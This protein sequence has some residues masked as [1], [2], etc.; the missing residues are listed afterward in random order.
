MFF[1]AKEV[2]R[3]IPI[4]PN[5]ASSIS[6]PP[7][8]WK[9]SKQILCYTRLLF[10]F[11][12]SLSSRLRKKSLISSMLSQPFP[13]AAILCRLFFSFLYAPFFSWCILAIF[14]WF[15]DSTFCL[16]CHVAAVGI[17][18]IIRRKRIQKQ[19]LL[20]SNISLCGWS[21]KLT[22]IDNTQRILE[23]FVIVSGAFL[24]PRSYDHHLSFR[25]TL[26]QLSR[27][28]SI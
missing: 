24:G 16:S 22:D 9:V 1:S 25:P 5:T 28:Y 7:S 17:C 12:Y 26:P 19:I 27:I 11:P 10:P 6:T 18:E 2:D 3:W 8:I 13:S 4:L 23:G 14:S 21:W 20:D 15:K